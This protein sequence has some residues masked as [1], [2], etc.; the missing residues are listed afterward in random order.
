MIGVVV[1]IDPS[2][3]LD[4]T[5]EGRSDGE[6]CCPGDCSTKSISASVYLGAWA[7]T[8]CA[9]GVGTAGRAGGAWRELR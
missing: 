7:G 2:D 5:E 3:R 9:A 1:D 6:Y 4:G 8:G